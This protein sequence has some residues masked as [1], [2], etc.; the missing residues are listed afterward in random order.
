MQYTSLFFCIHKGED[1]LA[2]IDMYAFMLRAEEPMANGKRAKWHG[3]SQ[4]MF[5][6]RRRELHHN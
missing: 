3:L 5:F 6:T 2:S 4:W 1:R